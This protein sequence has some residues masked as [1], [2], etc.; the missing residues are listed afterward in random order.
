MTF[1]YCLHK[2]QAQATP[3]GA[4]GSLAPVKLFAQ[5]RKVFWVNAGARVSDFDRDRRAVLKCAD[6]DGIA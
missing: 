3:F 6:F 2:S 1:D 5:M 4:S